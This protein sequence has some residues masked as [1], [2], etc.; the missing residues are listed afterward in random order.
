MLVKES[1]LNL[2]EKNGLKCDAVYFYPQFVNINM[3]FERIHN[4]DYEQIALCHDMFLM[5]PF[6]EEEKYVFSCL[7]NELII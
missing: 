3:T 1:N 7:R 2:F 6:T 4:G 5:K